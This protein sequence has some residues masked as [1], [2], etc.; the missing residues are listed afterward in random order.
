MKTRVNLTTEPNVLLLA[1]L[2]TLALTG[3][4]SDSDSDSTDSASDTSTDTD[5]DTS[6]DTE[7]DYTTL[8][9]NSASYS[10]WK[11][12][13]LSA[14]TVLDLSD[15]EAASSTEWD[16]A[17]QRYNVKLNGG[18]SGPGNVQAALADAQDEFYDDDGNAIA[19]VFTNADA[20]TEAAALSVVYDTSSLSYQADAYEPA[21]TDWYAYDFTT[22]TISADT[23]VGYL[24][25]HA[26]AAT[27]SRVYITAVGSTGI[28][29]S[30]ITQAADTVQF[31]E[32]EYSFSATFADDASSSDSTL[33]CLDLDSSAAVDCDSSDDWEW[34][35]EY[36]ASSHAVNIW[37]NGGVYGDG[38]AAV[39]GPIDSTE[40]A[41]YTSATLVDS[42]DISGHYSTDSS[43]GLFS[44]QS[45]WEY[46]LTS[47]HLLWPNFRTYLIDLDSSDDSSDQ[48]ALQISDYYSLG[49]SGSPEL[50]FRSLA[51]E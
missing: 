9:V 30:Y 35:Y 34:M 48:I 13:D 37:T 32:T 47:S 43:T 6:T 31:A 12:I 50:R 17:L 36:N 49:D 22:H 2:A 42:T 16:I 18:D 27:Y 14:G 24:V 28:S 29:L 41:E 45:W 15:E 21:T 39:F 7:S 38:S 33:I 44:E 11:Y 4:G 5:T 25:R 3:C 23:S 1:L 46:N 10:S 19:S 8:Q 40:L 26:D 51:T 20:D